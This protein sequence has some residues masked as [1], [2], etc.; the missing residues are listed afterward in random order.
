MKYIN[1]NLH[2]EQKKAIT[3][4]LVR[5]LTDEIIEDAANAYLTCIEYRIKEEIKKMQ[6]RVVS[7][8][9]NLSSFNHFP[10]NLEDDVQFKLFNALLDFEFDG[11]T[12][13]LKRISNNTEQKYVMIEYDRLETKRLIGNIYYK[14]YQELE[15]VAILVADFIFKIIV[16][17]KVEVKKENEQ[18][19]VFNDNYIKFISKLK[20]LAQNKGI[21][22]NVP[23][24]EC[25]VIE[26][27][28]SF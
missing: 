6:T 18:E 24:C 20:Q 27:E 11:Y 9:V 25:G 7:G 28:F 12:T 21:T 17:I 23:L 19:Y 5:V 2:Q 15:T 13:F 1:E 3:N 26:Y 8:K 22:I 4:E 10:M 16:D 14:Y